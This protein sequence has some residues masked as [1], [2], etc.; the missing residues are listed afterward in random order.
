VTEGTIRVNGHDIR[1]L[2]L[3]DLRRSVAVLFQDYTLFPLSVSPSINNFCPNPFEQVPEK[4]KDNIALGNP[5][6][7]TDLKLIHEAAR[8]G[9][10]DTV[11]RR[12]PDNLDTYIS[13]P[14]SV[15]DVI[16][17]Q[18]DDQNG[19]IDNALRKLTGA[20]PPQGLSG[21]QLQRIAV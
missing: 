15:H 2:K 18:R 5:K 8:L 3:D 10:A 19:N 21:G 4:V 16:R 11:I 13:R 9:G 1:Q 20:K 14:D 17:I 7:A 6:Y 12:L